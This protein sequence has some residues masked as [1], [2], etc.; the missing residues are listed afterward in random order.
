M[1][2]ARRIGRIVVALVALAALAVLIGIGITR[3]VSSPAAPAPD[4]QRSMPVEFVGRANPDW[5]V[6]PFAE[7]ENTRTGGQLATSIVVTLT[8]FG[9]QSAPPRLAATFQT[10]QGP[11]VCDAPRRASWGPGDSVDIRLHCSFYV[12]SDR[13]N[14]ARN[15][16]VSS[17]E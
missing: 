10:D 16:Q 2:R 11:Y 12:P 3:L 14:T 13:L 4:A 6:D 7:L 8:R 9:G 1:G 17:G 5:T 15:L